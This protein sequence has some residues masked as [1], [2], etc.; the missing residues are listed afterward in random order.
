MVG[1]EHRPVDG[2]DA[3]ERAIGERERLG[4]ALDEAD[5]ESL[6][7]RPLAP[8]VEQRRDVVDPHHAAA[9]AGGGDRG[10]PAPGRDVE[11]VRACPEVGG[12]AEALRHGDDQRGDLREVAAR[13]RRLLPLLEGFQIERGAGERGHRLSLR[14]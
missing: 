7:L 4:V 2:N 10:V 9:E 3:V 13:P 11:H 14:S 8:S 6:G 12:V 5:I 1:R